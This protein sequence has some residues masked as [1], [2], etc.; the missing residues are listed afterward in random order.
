MSQPKITN[1]ELI[2]DMQEGLTLVSIAEKYK[3]SERNVQRRKAAIVKQGWSPEHNMTKM[4]PEE[5]NVKG[6]STL[7]D[8]SGNVKTQWV[9]TQANPEVLSLSAFKEG[10]L[11]FSEGLNQ[12][13]LIPPTLYVPK[14]TDLMVVYPLGDPHIGMMAWS[15][16]TGGD[17]WDLKIAEEVLS[18]AYE[19]V[20]IASPPAENAV[21]L[22]LGDFFH[23]DNQEGVTV[24]S[25]N[26]LD[27]D[28][29]YA[30]MIAVGLNIIR[31][32][33]QTALLHHTYVRVINVVGNHDETG[34]LFLSICLAHIYE[35]NP[36]VTID[37]DPGH[38][39]YVK[40]GKC[41]I[42]AH[43]GQLCKMEKLPHVMAASRSEDWGQTKYRYWLTGHIHHD[44]KK[45]F[46]GCMVESFRTMAA[47]DAY[48]ISGGWLSGRDTK[49]IIYHKDYGE[50]ERRIINIDLV[51]AQLAR[52]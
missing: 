6:T 42:G 24:K 38:F 16:E 31:K 48:A 15:E 20:I 26:I 36:R 13:E 11:E 50:W 39:H 46:P 17:N 35:L 18:E 10:M 21:I 8:A 45:E 1:E 47:P 41:L 3:M 30:K 40:F 32:M 12:V 27:R 4:C 44:S 28:G 43:H 7:Y 37:T 22:N 14:E 33:I 23:Y 29:R 51:K 2:Q 52:K 34:A 19:R 25:R 9:K 5:Y 49:A